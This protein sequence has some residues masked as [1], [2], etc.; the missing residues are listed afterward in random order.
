MR[1]GMISRNAA[2]A[3][4]LRRSRRYDIQPL[5]PAEAR[6]WV[7]GASI[8]GNRLLCLTHGEQHT[9]RHY[10]PDG[11]HLPKAGVAK[12]RYVDVESRR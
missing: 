4:E 3:V 6:T 8:D 12:R 11:S 1:W 10:L 5:T 7:G 2:M 9:I